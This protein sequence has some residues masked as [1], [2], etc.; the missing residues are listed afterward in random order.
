MKNNNDSIFVKC[1]CS[2]HLF[3]CE[4]FIYE[5]S[6]GECDKGF[7]LS[8]WICGRRNNILGWKER[9]RWIWNILKTGK[10]WSDGIIINDEQS[11]EIIKFFKKHLVKTKGNEDEFNINCE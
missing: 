10:P 6:N 7:N 5:Y 4:R 2:G 8:F 9:W 3:E 1:Q 11:V